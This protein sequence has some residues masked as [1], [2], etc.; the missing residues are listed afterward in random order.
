MIFISAAS[1]SLTNLVK[2]EIGEVRVYQYLD[3]SP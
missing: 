1:E 2:S 3:A